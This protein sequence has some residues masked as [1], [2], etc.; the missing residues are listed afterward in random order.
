MQPPRKRSRDG[1]DGD[2]GSEDAEP[3]DDSVD[4]SLEVGR[5]F[6]RLVVDGCCHQFVEAL[7]VVR[8]LP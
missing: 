5:S 2:E 8:I 3:H 7:N 4:E 1:R 6:G